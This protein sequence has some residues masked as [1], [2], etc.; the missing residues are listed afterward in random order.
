MLKVAVVDDNK[1][2]RKKV[3]KRI[4]RY[5]KS[6]NINWEVAHLDPLK[7]EKDYAA[8]IVK[9]KVIILIVDEKLNVMPNSEGISVT[10]SGHDIVKLLRKTNKQL[11]IYVITAYDQDTVLQGMKGAFDGI[12][13]RNLFSIKE[14]SDQYLQRFVRATQ[15][16][17]INYQSEYERLGELSEL[18]A[19]DKA[20]DNEIRELKGLQTKLQIPL[21]SLLSNDR[22]AWINKLEEKTNKLESLSEKIKKFLAE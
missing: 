8:W 21:T 3:A 14:N 17:L 4:A 20:S 6:E 18:V 9:N 13:N 12:V 2:L 16:Y 5:L 19:L 11:P 15:T 1:E 7:S 10:Y 22:K